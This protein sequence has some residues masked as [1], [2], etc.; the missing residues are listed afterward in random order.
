MA[1][2]VTVYALLRVKN[3]R[4][5]ARFFVTSRGRYNGSVQA[6]DELSQKIAAT[7]GD[8]YEISF[9]NRDDGAL[10]T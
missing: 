9:W 5:C 3:E 1:D 2:Q 7:I 8:T 10:T 6:Y 4:D